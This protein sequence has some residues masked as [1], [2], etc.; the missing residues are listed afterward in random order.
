M[1]A[2]PESHYE[3]YNQ[4]SQLWRSKMLLC[5]Q[6]L[7]TDPS[8]DSPVS[9]AVIFLPFGRSKSIASVCLHTHAL[10][11]PLLCQCEVLS[12]VP[13]TSRKAQVL[14]PLFN[15][16]C[17]CVITWYIAVSVVFSGLKADCY[18]CRGMPHCFTLDIPVTKFALFSS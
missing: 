18:G 2:I 6:H 15:A 9:V 7:A 1:R 3:F 12:G 10:W 11:Q 16:S 13:S 14:L 17:I 5:R 8:T 4:A